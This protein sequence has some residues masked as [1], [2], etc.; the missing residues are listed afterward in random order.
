[1]CV[2]IYVCVQYVHI[3]NIHTHFR[4]CVYI[5]THINICKCVSVCLYITLMQL[6]IKFQFKE[7]I[8][9]AKTGEAWTV[10]NITKI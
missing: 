9:Q 7:A 5:F 3:Y 4:V 8:V 2:Y 10:K 6:N 1:M